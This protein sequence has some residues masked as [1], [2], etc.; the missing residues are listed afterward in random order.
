MRRQTSSV[1]AASGKSGAIKV[2]RSGRQRQ[3]IAAVLVAITNP[4]K[5]TLHFAQRIRTS[6]RISQLG[7]QQT[8]NQ[9]QYAC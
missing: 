7:R 8:V 3:A 1:F 6:L 9:Q 4:S 2:L 5:S